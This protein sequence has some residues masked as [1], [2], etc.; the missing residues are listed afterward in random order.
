MGQEVEIEQLANLKRT[1]RIL[2]N[3]WL[4]QWFQGFVCPKSLCETNST[5]QKPFV[6]HEMRVKIRREHCLLIANF[7][8]QILVF[9]SHPFRS[10]HN[11]QT[12]M[13]KGQAP[14]EEHV[15]GLTTGTISAELNGG[16][17]NEGTS[18]HD[19]I[20]LIAR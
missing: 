6:P 8:T 9:R 16:A 13:L 10:R 11:G 17:L 18:R 1:L 15:I 19:D 3:E 7:T 4:V 20:V 2:A 14:L 5:P 12:T